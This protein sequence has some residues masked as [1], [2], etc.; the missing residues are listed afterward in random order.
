MKPSTRLFDEDRNV[1]LSAYPRSPPPKWPPI[2]RVRALT[3]TLELPIDRQNHQH[4]I[5]IIVMT[6]LVNFANIIAN[7]HHHNNH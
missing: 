4:V 3:S 2:R 7:V 5:A 1:P 6:M